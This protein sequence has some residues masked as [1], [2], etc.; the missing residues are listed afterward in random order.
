MLERLGRYTGFW[1]LLALIIAALAGL[2]VSDLTNTALEPWAQLLKTVAPIGI[3]A[4]VVLA[5]LAPF[6][7]PVARLSRW[8]REHQMAVLG[9][10]ALILNALAIVVTGSWFAGVLLMALVVAGFGM[11]LA[12]HAPPSAL[13]SEGPGL[14]LT[15]LG[16]IEDRVSPDPYRPWPDNYLDGTFLLQGRLESAG[17]VD[18][19]DLHGIDKNGKPTGTRWTRPRSETFWALGVA[20]QV[21]EEWVSITSELFEIEPRIPFALLLYASDSVNT[22][23]RFFKVGARFRVTLT[24]EDGSTAGTTTEI[25]ASALIDL[26]A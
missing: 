16:M 6:V 25:P 4:C 26:T 2:A 7:E 24:F 5:I 9:I 11:G 23:E 21:N 12:F 22:T 15:W 10:A 20:R 14:R 13:L 19:I 3:V 8:I 17:W 1:T 18:R